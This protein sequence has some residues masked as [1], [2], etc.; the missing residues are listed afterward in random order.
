M[1]LPGGE[2]KEGRPRS[3]AKHTA[4]L[5]AAIELLEIKGIAAMTI[6]EV[7]ARAGIAKTTIYRRWSS[8]GALAIEGFLHE[9]STKMYYDNS[10]S[11][12]ADLK[13][14]LKRVA[15]TFR[16]PTGRVIAGLIAEA[17]RDPETMKAFLNG[18]VLLRRQI[19]RQLFQRGVEIGEFRPDINVETAID[20][21]YA[22]MYYRLLMNLGDYEPA[23]IE[24]YVDIVVAGLNTT[25]KRVA[26]P[27][28]PKARRTG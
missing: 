27:S 28:P 15:E 16:S 9:M 3:L 8:K 21:F 6:E 7:A 23:D 12:I 14:Q 26:A 5:K 11:V 4:I 20:L 24:T 17:Q 22:P 19:T 2:T 10:P 18:Y 13:A 1:K 25:G